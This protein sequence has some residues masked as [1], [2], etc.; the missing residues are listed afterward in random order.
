MPRPGALVLEI[1]ARIG[2]GVGRGFPRLLAEPF[3]FAVLRLRFGA[4]LAPIVMGRTVPLWA[5]YETVR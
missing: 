1:V 2:V 4:I 5:G 3:D